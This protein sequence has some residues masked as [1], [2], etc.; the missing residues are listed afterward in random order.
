MVHPGNLGRFW[1]ALPVLAGTPKIE[2]DLLPIIH[3]AKRRAFCCIV[4]VLEGKPVP[5]AYANSS[6]AQC[7]P[8]RVV[9]VIEE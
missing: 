8:G 3:D 5:N 7:D 1:N 2:V 9:R 4:R 6:R